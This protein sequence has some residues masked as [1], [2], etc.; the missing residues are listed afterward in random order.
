M[1][2]ESEKKFKEIN[3]AYSTLSDP[4]KRSLY[5]QYGEEANKANF[6]QRDHYSASEGNHDSFP[7]WGSSYFSFAP[8]NRNEYRMPDNPIDSINEMF[9]KFF[10]GFNR[11]PLRKKHSMDAYKPVEIDVYCTLEELFT[12]MVYNCARID[13]LFNYP[14]CRMS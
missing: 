13:T 11:Q 3:E 4:K 14:T 12:G 1:Q 7:G 8:R 5:D 10:N 6:G 2:V 9:D